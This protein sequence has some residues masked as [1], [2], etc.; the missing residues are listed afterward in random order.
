MCRGRDHLHSSS[1]TAEGG[2]DDDR[3]AVRL[4][5]SDQLRHGAQ[6]IGAAGQDRH[7][8][9]F[10]GTP[11]PDL[12]THRLDGGG[13]RADKGYVSPGDRPGEFGVLG[14]KAV[15]RVQAVRAGA[16]EQAE[17]R[18]AVQVALRR[19][20]AAEGIGLVGE[21]YVHGAV[22][23]IGVHGDGG[24]PELPARPHDPDRDLAPVGDQDLLQH[25]VPSSP[26]P[27]SP[28]RRK[29]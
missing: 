7:A 1:A 29:A 10:R 12:V 26:V 11:R 21:A 4:A 16:L 17:N 24:H 2:L 27:S 20:L 15:A 6:G 28:A 22:V 23:R 14:Q 3:P 25:A 18:L 13:R 9:G 19:G 8:C 5:E